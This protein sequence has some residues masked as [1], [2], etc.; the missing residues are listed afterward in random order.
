M[1]P[2]QFIYYLFS[3]ARFL[4]TSRI[5]KF[6]EFSAC[7][8]EEDGVEKARASVPPVP[9]G[10]RDVAGRG[11]DGRAHVVPLRS[12]SGAPRPSPVRI[13][14]PTEPGDPGPLW[15]AQTCSLTHEMV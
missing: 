1:D 4:S 12:P 13:E 11:N 2:V 9:A 6:E 15:S 3:L 7:T 14:V 8:A 5:Q 10:L